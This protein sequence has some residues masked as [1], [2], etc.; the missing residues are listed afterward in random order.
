MDARGER[1]VEVVGLLLTGPVGTG[2]LQGTLKLVGPLPIWYPAQVQ[3]NC[4]LA[5]SSHPALRTVRAH[6]GPQPCLAVP[7]SPAPGHMAPNW[8]VHMS[9]HQPATC[10]LLPPKIGKRWPSPVTSRVPYCPCPRHGAPAPPRLLR[11]GGCQG[12]QPPALTV[13]V[14]MEREIQFLHHKGILQMEVSPEGGK[15]HLNPYPSL[16]SAGQRAPET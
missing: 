13:L 1:R 12:A 15:G 11:C 16:N 8:R 9:K 10:C 5:T 7:G 14:A 2:S 6:E 4:P 3:S